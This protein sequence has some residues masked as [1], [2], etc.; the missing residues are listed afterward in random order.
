M[1][2][3]KIKLAIVKGDGWTEWEGKG[4]Q[5][6]EDVLDTTVFISRRAQYDTSR[7]NIKTV[8]LPCSNENFFLKNY[9][10]YI[11]GQYKTLFGLEQKLAGFDIAQGVDLYN[12]FTLQAIR[13][14]KYNP[15]LKVVVQVVDNMPGRFEYN[16]W[17]GFKMPPRYWRKKINAVMAEVIEKADLFLAITQYSADM[18][19]F[20][21]VAENRIKVLAPAIIIPDKIEKKDL[22]DKLQLDINQELYLA[23][24]RLVK[25]KGVYDLIYG[26]RMYI[27]ENKSANKLLLIVGNGP[28]KPNLERLVKEW[29]LEKQVKIV[30]N[31]P[32]HLVRS[33]YRYAVCSI[34]GSSPTS[35]WQEQ[36]GF[37]LAEAI[38]SNCPVISTWSGAI[39]EVVG[40]AGILIPPGNYVELK[41]ALKKMDDKDFCSQLQANC[42]RIKYKYSLTYYRQVLL[43]AY[44]GILSKS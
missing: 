10:K 3:K 31:V 15:N 28:E 16:Y 19:R 11:K 43:E 21:G 39:P 41:N 42:D 38:S 20:L 24:N 34:L 8:G 5:E 7:V 6:L 36:F 35:V 9:F 18:L 14:K 32:N 29:G 25:E 33:L 12:Y 44:Q 4:W 40:D 30:S 27:K 17:P 37:V 1:E 2:I 22:F 13:A 26:W 23:V